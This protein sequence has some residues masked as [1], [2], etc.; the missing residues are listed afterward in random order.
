MYAVT[1][2][3]QTGAG[4]SE[5][6]LA[7]SNSLGARYVEALAVRRL[8]RRLRASARAVS[9]KELA[10]A[11]FKDRFVQ[12]LEA[13]LSS[14][15]WYGADFSA[16][17][18]PYLLFDD[19]PSSGRRELPG[20]ISDS[21]YINAIYDVAGQFVHDGEDL[22]LV[23]RAG[24]V[25]LD[26]DMAFHVGL[27]APRDFRVARVAE[28]LKIGVVEAEEVVTGLE[29]ARSAWFAKIAD[30][31]PMDRS[32]YSEVFDLGPDRPDGA[33]AD[34]ISSEMMRHRLTPMDDAYPSLYRLLN[35]QTV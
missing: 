19:Y 1:I 27:F 9:K 33:I 22:V 15:S 18:P 35:Q 20:E 24:C 16:G 25:T 23:K 8:A 30:A 6:G 2:G 28:R 10:F 17:I 4:A 29:N 26:H 13:I 31:D 7:V 34:A 12:K 14:M 11:S 32:L 3:G 21:E 5:I